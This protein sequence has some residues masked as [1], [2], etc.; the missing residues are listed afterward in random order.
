[1]DIVIDWKEI[2]SEDGFF[3]VFLPQVSAPEWHARNLNALGDSLVTGDVNEIE[4]PY[5]IINKNNDSVTGSLVEFQKI[6]F[7]IFQEAIEAKRD[8][9]VINK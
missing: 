9:N 6:V 2:K 4:P 3:E 8:I 1:M 7:D 5:T